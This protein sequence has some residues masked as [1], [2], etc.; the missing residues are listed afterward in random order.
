MK[1]FN[2]TKVLLLLA[3]FAAGMVACKKD[4]DLI[5]SPDEL[6]TGSYLRLDSSINRNINYADLNNSQVGIIV[7]GIGEEVD[8]VI[9]YVSTNNSTNLSTWRRVKAFKTADNK[10]T[11]TVRATEIAAALGIPATSLNPGNQ[12]ILWN[13][14]VTKSGR[15]FSLQNTN[16]E[17]ESSADYRMGL[18]WAT[19][20]ICPFD[21][22][23]SAGVYTITQDP[24]DG[25]TGATA[26]VTTTS[27][28]VTI[29]YLYPAAGLYN[30]PAQA[31]TINVNPATGAATMPKQV[32]GGYGSAFA[33]F[34]G[35][36][37]GYVFSCTGT[38]TLNVT[39]VSAGGT[40]Y[41][42]YPI[43]LKK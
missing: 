3:A 26:V 39:H 32:Y 13:E 40:S 1:L 6:I 35:Q 34:T 29:T 33:N 25:A 28:T 4:T 19:T 7:S 24:W 36:G 18:R 41:G 37:T 31:V 27:N 8:S 14:V 5:L 22:T 9:V 38:I 43:T 17:F 30:Q 11:L 10:A 21:P 2:A 42:T 12:Y 15:R 16:A 20:V 23:A